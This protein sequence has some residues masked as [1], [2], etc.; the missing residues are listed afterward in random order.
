MCSINDSDSARMILQETKPQKVYSP[1][2][3]SSS[4]LAQALAS[5]GSDLNTQ[6]SVG[7]TASRLRNVSMQVPDRSA[8]WLLFHCHPS[9]FL[10][11]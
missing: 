7:R 3:S 6:S 1:M 4:N 2:G 11:P 10:N 8:H 9:A 5:Q